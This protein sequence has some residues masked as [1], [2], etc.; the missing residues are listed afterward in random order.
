MAVSRRTTHWRHRLAWACLAR[1]EAQV[2]EQRSV[3]MLCMR[4]A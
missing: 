1:S 2:P 4:A 3:T